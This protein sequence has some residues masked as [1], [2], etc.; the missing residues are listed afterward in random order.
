MLKDV[1]PIVFWG[2][3]LLIAGFVGWGLLAPTSLGSVMGSAL[4]WVIGNFGWMFVLIAFSVLVLCIFLVLHPWGR[5]RLGP[6]D[7]RPEFG[8]FS[9][10][11]MMFAAGLGAGLLFYGIAEPVSHWSS[12]P[13]GLA[14][15][16][17]EAAA[18][19]ALR[20]TYFHWGFNG[21]AMYAVMGGAMA[22]FSFRKGLPVLVSS[23]FTPVLGDDASNKP[24]GRLVDALAI[25]ATLFGTATALGL[26]GLQLN[27]GLN[28]LTDSVPKSNAVAVSIILVVTL[29]FVV[30]ATSGVEKGI[31]FLA[32]L[33]SFATIG[34]FLFFLAVGGSTVLV[35]SQGIESIGTYVL[36]VLPMS[37]QTGVGD[38]QWMAGWTIFY[39]AWW[40]SWAPFVGMFVARISRGRTIREFIIGVVAAPTG[41]GFLW[42][43]VVGGTGI[44]L[45]RTGQAD[46]VGSLS[47]PELVLFTA[48]DVLPLPVVS[49]ALCIVLIALFFISGADAA[50]VVMATMASRGSIRPSKFVVV[51]LGLLMGGIACAML[52]VGGL[53]ALQQAAVLGSVPF[54]F[55]LV[56]VA[57]C[58]IKALR[59]ETREEP[60]PDVG[61]RERVRSGG[62]S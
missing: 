32:N 37:L 24:L 29:L 51:V 27:S 41:F 4:G 38:E 50:S 56:G 61:S 53:T 33:G 48:L 19:V 59:E 31:N 62:A 26:N 52:L 57:W 35:I 43:A 8:T 60:E 20:Y 47:T 39:W 58:W 40:V 46:I 16:E 54:M 23:A 55:V 3:A 36:Q 25:V 28:Y 17:S 11:S 42:F 30:S 2:S 15:P 5:L 34:L 21:W 10:I 44:E 49:T 14:E 13:H 7:S 22:Y 6:D 12:P 1:D 45:Q 9:W 18:L